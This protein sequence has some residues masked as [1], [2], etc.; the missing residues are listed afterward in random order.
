MD[1]AAQ[2]LLATLGAVLLVGGAARSSLDASWHWVPLWLPV[3]LLCITAA[4]V[5]H[6]SDKL[7]DGH[8]DR[9]QRK[10]RQPS[11]TI[12]EL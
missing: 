1:V 4:L 8:S 12:A 2:L 9:V 11:S 5:L 10:P 3:G 6:R 7:R